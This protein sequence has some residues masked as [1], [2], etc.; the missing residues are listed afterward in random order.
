VRVWRRLHLL[1]SLVFLGLLIWHVTF[2]VTLMVHA[3]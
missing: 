1:I 2:A 3:R